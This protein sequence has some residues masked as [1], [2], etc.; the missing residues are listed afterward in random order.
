M[1]N[2]ANLLATI[3]ANIYTNNN[4]EVTAAMVKSAVD[5]TVASL[6]AG[7]QF[8]GVATPAT[9]PGT[10]DGK[11][12]Y[13]ASRAGTYSYFGG[14]TLLDGEVAA[15]V[16]SGSSWSKYIIYSQSFDVNL[17]ATFRALGMVAKIS[18]DDIYAIGAVP[19]NLLS[20]Y[21]GEL[22]DR[23]LQISYSV[24]K[25][26]AGGSIPTNIIFAASAD[27]VWYWANQ[28]LM[29]FSYATQAATLVSNLPQLYDDGIISYDPLVGITFCKP[30]GSD[31]VLVLSAAY[32]ASESAQFAFGVATNDGVLETIKF[33]YKIVNQFIP[34]QVGADGQGVP[35]RYK[36]ASGFVR[37][38]VKTPVA[39]FGDSIV[40]EYFVDPANDV[41]KNQKCVLAWYINENL[42]LGGEYEPFTSRNSTGGKSV[43]EDADGNVVVIRRGYP[44]ETFS[45]QHSHNG[46]C[47]Q[48]R[49]AE[50]VA[51][52]PGS[53]V[54]MGGT[55]DFGYNCTIGTEDSTNPATTCGGLNIILQD[56]AENLP[57]CQIF[58]CTPIPRA[59]QFTPNTAG[60]ILED[61]VDAIK[62]V[63]RR[64]SAKVIDLYADS[65]IYYGNEVGSEHT[66]L[67]DGIHPNIYGFERMTRIIA[68]G[69]LQTI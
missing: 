12:Y 56:I 37:P 22:E 58:V 65:G 48:D 49:I 62:A 41:S 9:N 17:S 69:I 36:G 51:L 42:G 55:N 25:A 54:I 16:G 52:A 4:N 7:Y 59:T 3:A 40:S 10:P 14:A 21:F 19:G 47:L 46:G 33:S 31:P 61:Y 20:L 6:G 26:Y 2:Y 63:A 15:F 50:L 23:N 68:D 30:D 24:A 32:L 44:D 34:R 53:I 39:L 11:Y 5:Q 27:Y 18:G 8:M 35:M 64:Y 38:L 57:Y 60:N 43:I 66:F 29:K 28:S 1:A 13:L 45:N 67:I